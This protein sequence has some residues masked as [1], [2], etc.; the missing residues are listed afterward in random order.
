MQL[1]DLLLSLIAFGAEFVGTISGFGS[2]TFFVPAALFLES[3]Q[4][5]LALTGILHCFGNVFKLI[6]FR[7]KFPWRTFFFLALPAVI[8]TGIGA[9][10]A[11]VY[12]STL[13]RPVLGAFLIFVG[14]FS[15][16]MKS[17]A[18]SASRPV[19]LLLSILS[20]IATG[21]VGTG[22]ALR[23]LALTTLQVP[24]L[25]FVAL[26]SAI[27]F[28]GD[29]LRTA[30]YLHSGFMNWD[31]W[32]YIPLLGVGAYLGARLGRYVLTRLDQRHFERIVAFFVI[33]SGLVLLI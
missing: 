8:S 32:Y 25:S 16:F 2:S 13:F 31:E 12:V 7:E 24:K 15:L 4:F 9:W 3:A 19:A 1:H 14:L 22:G 10:L 17:R 26:S 21:L 5:V 11:S 28:G 29:L 30:I 23:G 6:L 20:G 18:L 27:D 33:V